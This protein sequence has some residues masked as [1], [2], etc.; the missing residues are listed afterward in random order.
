[1]AETVLVTVNHSTVLDE[2]PPDTSGG[3]PARKK[4]DTGSKSP[5]ITSISPYT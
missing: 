4:S 1:M 2:P 3:Q 5:G